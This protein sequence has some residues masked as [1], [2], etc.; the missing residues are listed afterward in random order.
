MVQSSSKSW[1]ALVLLK[2]LR[3]KVTGFDFRIHL[4]DKKLKIGIIWMTYTIANICC[5]MKN[6]C[7]SMY[8]NGSIISCAGPILTLRT[9]PTKTLF[10]FL[11]NL[12]S[13]QK[14]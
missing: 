11:L 10:V 12:L 1:N 9:N 14:T 3:S 2:E 4:N 13:N 7:F 6:Y 5:A 8:K